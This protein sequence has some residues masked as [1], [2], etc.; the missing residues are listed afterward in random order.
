M[1]KESILHILIYG[2]LTAAQM[3]AIYF[4]YLYSQT[5]TFFNTVFLGVFVSWVKGMLFPFF[6]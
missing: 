1:I 3:F 4:L 6:L 2:Y 5:N